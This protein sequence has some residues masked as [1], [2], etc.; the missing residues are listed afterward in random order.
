MSRI[1]GTNG[2]TL[3]PATEFFARKQQVE[4]ECNQDFIERILPDCIEWPKK[5]NQS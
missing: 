2:K 4:R 3:F 1:H 5:V